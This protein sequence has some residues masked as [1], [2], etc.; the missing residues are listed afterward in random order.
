[1]ATVFPL[2]EMIAKNCSLSK[3]GDV[4]STGRNLHLEGQDN[5]SRVPT[6]Y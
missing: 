2:H 6:L 3:P 1:M 5:Q 4:A